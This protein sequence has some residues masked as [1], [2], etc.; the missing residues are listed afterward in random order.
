MFFNIHAQLIFC[1]IFSPQPI[2]KMGGKPSRE[3]F[4]VR[5]L[6]H[7]LTDVMTFPFITTGYDYYSILTSSIIKQPNLFYTLPVAS[8]FNLRYISDT[9]AVQTTR[10]L[11]TGIRGQLCYSIFSCDAALYS[12]SGH[13][14]H[15]CFYTFEL[16]NFLPC[17][18]F[19]MLP[20]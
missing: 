1:T 13:K 7:R 20:L 15:Q 16:T 4:D 10:G 6:L 14:F 5:H 8:H 3:L 19:P 9:L 2:K 17:Q 11:Q 18:C 12:N